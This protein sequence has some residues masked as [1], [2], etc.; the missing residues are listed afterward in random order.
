MR[1]LLFATTNEGKRKELEAL[2][3]PGWIVKSARDLAA[4][5]EV[6]E[7]QPTFEGNAAKKA[8]AFAQATGLLALADDSGLCVDA[9]GGRPG[10][11]SARYAPGTDGDRIAKLLGELQGVPDVKR[12]AQFVCV[13]CLAAPDGQEYFA[14]GTCEGRITHAPR[15]THGFGYDPI[16][17][18]P[19]GKTMAELTRDEKSA[20]SHRGAAFRT[21]SAYLV[22][23][24]RSP[25]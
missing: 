2:L 23:A 13:L 20:V 12:M 9:L 22:A 1:T 3:G 4:P 6:D 18:L 19:N 24:G 14:R 5:V 16:F 25:P 8:R 10:V 21:M 15:G 7:D 11:Q 17:E